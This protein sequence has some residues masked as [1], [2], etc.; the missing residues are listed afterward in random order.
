M[1]QKECEVDVL[2]QFPDTYFFLLVGPIQNVYF[3]ILYSYMHFCIW[4]Y[5]YVH[6]VLASKKNV[7]SRRREREKINTHTTY[8]DKWIAI[9]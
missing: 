9:G 6:L 2:P 1:I 4:Q 8:W 7:D 3:D 5:V